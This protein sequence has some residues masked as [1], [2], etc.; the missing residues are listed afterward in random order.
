MIN[1]CS[2]SLAIFIVSLLFANVCLADST[3]INHDPYERFNRVMFNFND[4]LDRYV[5]KPVA[6]LYNKII[7]K[8]VS[9]G[10][11]NMFNNLDNVT[12]VANDL[13]QGHLY[14]ATSDLWRLGLNSTVGLLGFFD[15]AQAMGLERNKEDLGLT[16]AHWGYK[17]SNYLVLPILGPLTVRDALSWPIN[18]QYLTVYPY[19]KSNLTRHEVYVLWVVSTRAESLRFQNVMQL[20]AVDRYAFMRDAY[21]QH[22]NYLIDRNAQ[23]GLLT[24]DKIQP[25]VAPLK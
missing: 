10:I 6:T 12:T 11:G 1:K 8:P 15:V 18:Y 4:T 5:L 21:L 3:T 7:P 23:F 16:F 20:A 24:A 2:R 13:L 17:N 25:S 19:I 14:Q 9:K 22:R